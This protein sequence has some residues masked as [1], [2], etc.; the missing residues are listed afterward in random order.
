MAS[1]PRLSLLHWILLL[2]VSVDS[3]TVTAFQVTEGSTVLLSC[4][5]SVKH[6]GLSHVCWGRD[7]GTFWCNNIIVQ[8]DENGV[9]SK[10]SDRY[11]LIGD[12][13]SGQMDLGI[14]KIQTTD[15]GPYCCRVDIEGYFNDKKVSYT[16]T[17]MKATTTV[18]PTTTTE[19]KGTQTL[20]PLSDHTIAAD[21]S[22]SE[23]SLQNVTHVHSGVMEGTPLKEFA[24][25]F[26]ATARSSGFNQTKLKVIFNSCLDEPLGLAEMRRLKPL[27]FMDQ[28]KLLLDCE[29]SKLSSPADVSTGL[30]SIPEDGLHSSGFWASPHAPFRLL[31]RTC[32]ADEEGGSRGTLRPIPPGQ[33]WAVFPFLL[34]SR[35]HVRW[36]SQ[37]RRSRRGGWSCGPESCGPNVEARSSNRHQARSS[38]RHQARSSNR[39][40]ARS[41]NRH[42]AR[43][44]NRHQARSSNRHQARSSNRHQARSSNRHQARSSN[45]HQ[46]RSTNRHQARSSRALPTRC[47]SR[48][49]VRRQALS[50]RP[51]DRRQALSSRPSDRRQALSSRPSDRRQALSSRPS[52]R[53]QALSSRPSDR[54]QALSSRPS[55][56]RQALS[57]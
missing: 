14:Q 42:Q 19:P 41:S 46:A 23:I 29:W 48:N 20:S 13:L 30:A 28:L 39:H 26:L 31:Q 55:D 16:L 6:H 5:Y 3:S 10:V 51:S 33:N 38:N 2:T 36:V 53:R 4:H 54:R 24:M 57:S 45:R 25:D 56:R 11:R 7:C 8:T 35:P 52:D 32:S 9:I 21:S 37:R 12:V 15:S 17:V 44:S 22:L 43:S 1:P 18:P 49:P 27:G 40:Q 34:R 50:S 47:S